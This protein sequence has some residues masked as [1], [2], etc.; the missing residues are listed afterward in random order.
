MSQDEALDIPCIRACF[1]II[2]PNIRQA[3]LSIRKRYLPQFILA[4]FEII[5]QA[6]FVIAESCE[7]AAVCDF[8][9]TRDQARVSTVF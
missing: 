2:D 3:I 9:W 6:P 8:S 1:R 4:V 7:Q 5:E